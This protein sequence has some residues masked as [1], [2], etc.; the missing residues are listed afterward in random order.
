MTATSEV[1]DPFEG[2]TITST[3]VT[4]SGLVIALVA[5][6]ATTAFGLRY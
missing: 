4:R 6:A 5:V 1:R 3:I 2:I